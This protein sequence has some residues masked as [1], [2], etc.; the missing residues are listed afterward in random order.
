MIDLSRFDQLAEKL[1]DALPESLQTCRDDVKKN[2]RVILEAN[3]AKLDLVTREE[4]DVQQGVLM[5]TRQQ[6]N[7]LQERLSHLEEK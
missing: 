7:A 1:S 6:L 5:R 3:L 4:F 2:F